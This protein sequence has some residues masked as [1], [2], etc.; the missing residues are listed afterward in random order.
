MI[1][2]CTLFLKKAVAMDGI[3]FSVSRTP[4]RE[5]RIAIS[6][7]L[8]ERSPEGSYMTMEDLKEALDA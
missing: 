8:G 5:T 7:A 4:S 6:D 3:P 1:T 2:A